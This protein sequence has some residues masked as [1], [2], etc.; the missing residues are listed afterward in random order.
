MS[1]TPAPPPIT[2]HQMNILRAVTAMAWSD[3]VLEEEEVKV[4]ATRLSQGFR[5]HPEGQTELAQQIREYFTQRIPLA[6]VLPKVPNPEDRRLILKLGYLVIASSARTPEEPRINME[7]QAAFQQLVSAL[8]LP[9][10]VVESVSEEASQ[11]LGDVQVDPIEVLISGFTQ[12]YS[13]IA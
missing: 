13:R 10:S 9:D 1:A 8:D 6:E 2:P 3:G 5:P 11:E 4:M 7:E 12:H